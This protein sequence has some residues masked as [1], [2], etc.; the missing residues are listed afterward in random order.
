M[1]NHSQPLTEP[2]QQQSWWDSMTSQQ[3]VAYINSQHERR[4]AF[5]KESFAKCTPEQQARGAKQHEAMLAR[6]ELH[7][8]EKMAREIKKIAASN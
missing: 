8:D 3:R 1:S 7:R 2:Q 6:M 5:H 4:A